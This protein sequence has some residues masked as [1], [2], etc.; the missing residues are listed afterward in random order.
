[1]FIDIVIEIVK[2]ILKLIIRL[3]SVILSSLFSLL[4]LIII[5]AFIGRFINYQN[6]KITS[7]VGIDKSEY[8]TIGGIEQYIQIR[9]ENTA[10]PI[11]LFLHGGPGSNMSYYSYYWQTDLEKEFTIVHWDQR[12]S[13]NTYYKNKGTSQ[14]PTMDILL[15]DLDELIDYICK[16][17]DKEKVILL[18]H[19]WGTALGAIYSG[20]HPEKILHYISVSQMVDT[21]RAEELSAKEAIS[22]AKAD[23]DDEAAK[24]IE[25]EFQQV[26][27]NKDITMMQF[28]KYRNI[29]S[30]KL[31][32]GDNMSFIEMISMGVFSPYMTINDLRWYLLS[33][34]NPESYFEPNAKLHQSLLSNDGF[35]IYDYTS[36]Y[37][38]PV[39]FIAG[40][41]DWIT[42][43]YLTE[44]YFNDI[45]S[46]KKEMIYIENA[47]HTPFLDKSK[48]FC[49][50]ILNLDIVD[51]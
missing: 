47:G 32:S 39:T 33:M 43:Y 8:V 27:K 46:P 42:P 30:S 51:N 28:M 23:G 6:H 48:E 13:G 37:K 17:Y 35:S 34:F 26:Y 29:V 12:G 40:D 50:I 10:N 3:L 24:E 4:I 16:E 7:D 19:S 49:D 22:L 44:E 15:S 2:N 11:M 5:V 31:P 41:C 18:G 38:V 21:W 9:G 45:S 1:M 14:E 20:E 25:S 36:E